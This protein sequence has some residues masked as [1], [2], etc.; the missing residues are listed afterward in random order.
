MDH[1]ITFTEK[2][3]L[4]LETNTLHYPQARDFWLR[5]CHLLNLVAKLSQYFLDNFTMN[6]G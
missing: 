3:L 4:N 5:L 1:R 2:M 6:I